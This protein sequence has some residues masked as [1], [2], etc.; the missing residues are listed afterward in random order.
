MAI[1]LETDDLI[2]VGQLLKQRLGKRI[3]PATLWRWRLKGINGARLEC[4]LCGGCWMTTAKSF[5][6]W[7]RAQTANCQPAPLDT[8]APAERSA[9]TTKKLAAAGLL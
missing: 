8:D 4:V 2:P 3:S 7:V 1:N 5:A 6:D 9:A